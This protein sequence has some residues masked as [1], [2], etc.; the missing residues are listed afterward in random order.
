[1]TEGFECSGIEFLHRETRCCR[2]EKERLLQ[3]MMERG[4]ES[5][6]VMTIVIVAIFAALG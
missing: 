1:M 3:R 5:V 6:I 4:L 2:V